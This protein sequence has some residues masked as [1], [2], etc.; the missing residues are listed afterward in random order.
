MEGRGESLSLPKKRRVSIK[1]DD[2][3]P[4]VSAT[5]GGGE[6]ERKDFLDIDAKLLLFRV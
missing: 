2:R 1:I 6:R 5:K 4:C 3:V